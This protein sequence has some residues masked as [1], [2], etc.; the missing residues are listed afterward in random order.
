LAPTA[1]LP[2]QDR[3]GEQ[4]FVA[5]SDDGG[6]SWPRHAVVFEDPEK[7]RGY[8]EQKLA[9]IDTERVMAVSWTVT[10]GEVEDL[11]NSFALSHDGGLTWQ[12]AQSTGIQGQTMTPIPLGDERLLVLY[13]RRYG[14]Q[15]IV[16][17]LVS[18]TDESWTVHSE[19]LMYD[20]Q[21]RRERPEDLESG[22]EEFY[23]FKFGFPT[24]IRLQD[25]TYLATHWCWEEGSFGIRWTKLK[26]HWPEAA[27]TVGSEPEAPRREGSTP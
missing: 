23:L 4:V 9:E 21:T 8:F 11:E 2:A 26:I 18:Y 5:I 7:R 16:M 12:P 13:N 6:K 20:P 1:T 3:L 15:G 10:L 19:D 17:S 24:A 27:G 25:G 22:V 14:Q